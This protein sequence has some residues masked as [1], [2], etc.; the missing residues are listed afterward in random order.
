[1]QNG[2][3]V[4]QFGRASKTADF[5]IFSSFTIERPDFVRIAIHA[6]VLLCRRI[7]F[8]WWGAWS[9][10]NADASIGRQ[11]RQGKQMLVNVS[12]LLSDRVCLALRLSLSFFLSFSLSLSLFLF[13]HFLQTR[14]A[15]GC[16]KQARPTDK[17]WMTSVSNMLDQP[18]CQPSQ[19]SSSHS[20]TLLMQRSPTQ[21]AQP[22]SLPLD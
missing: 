6:A 4:S 17:S 21:L 3:G 8:A 1:M 5:V 20:I 13:H 9:Q 22:A 15:R 16:N 12:S 7:S 11:G 14:P 10:K 2:N 18:N 19:P